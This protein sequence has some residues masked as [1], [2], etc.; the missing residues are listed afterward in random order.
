[1]DISPMIS[2]LVQANRQTEKYEANWVSG[3]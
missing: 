1:M 2:E 3:A